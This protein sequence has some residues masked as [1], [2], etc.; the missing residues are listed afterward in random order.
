[1]RKR[2]EEILQLLIRSQKKI[3]IFSLKKRYQVTERTIRSDLAEINEF[4]RNLRISDIYFDSEGDLNTGPDFDSV[5]VEIELI[6]MN[7]YIYKMS[8]RERQVYITLLL[9]WDHKYLVMKDIA[10]KLYVSRLTVL[11]DFESIKEELENKEAEVLGDA[12]KG[13]CIRCSEE[14]R[15][16]LLVDLFRRLTLEV[17]NEGFFQRFVLEQLNI[18]YT[19]NEICSWAQ[20]YLS[21]NNLVFIAD[22]L[23]DTVLYLFVVF[24]LKSGNQ[25]T[26]LVKAVDFNENDDLIMYIGNKLGC[27]VSEE[28]RIGFRDYIR[29]YEISLYVKNLDEIEFY[30][31]IIHFLS[32]IDQELHLKLC[33]DNVLIDSLLLHIKNMR[34]WG[35]LEF[36]ISDL[37]EMVFDYQRVLTVVDKYLY[38][39]E[40]YLSY[41][42][43]DNMKKSI[44]IHICVAM[45]R[46]NKKSQKPSVV[47]VCPG[48]M[49]T[50][51]YLEAQIKNYF[52]FNI[53][54]L[55]PVSRISKQLEKIDDVDFIISTVQLHHLG[56][57]CLKVHAVLTMQ[58]MNL[59]QKTAFEYQNQQSAETRLK[60]N[61]RKIANKLQSLQQDKE[62][63]DRLYQKIETVILEYENEEKEVEKTAIGELLEEDSIIF[64]DTSQ[65]WEESIRK[66][67][68]ILIRKG[69][70][71]PK[72]VE[73]A[74]QN[75]RDYGDYIILGNG[76]AL[77]HAGK[78]YEVYKDGLSLLVSYPGIA[79]SSSEKK[80]NFLF[81][82]S[83]RGVKDY[84]ELFHEIVEI[85]QNESFRN[86]L[87]RMSGEELCQTLCFKES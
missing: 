71:G 84:I 64:D 22:A 14:K 44:M 52:D 31:I 55:F 65:D 48:S 45:I 81:C 47:I 76:V 34:D 43:N 8:P 11:N 29:N 51:R 3:S 36:E 39:L 63:P 40:K 4:L 38:V 27:P 58:D 86:S 54:G 35:D 24:N 15:K 18:Q 60:E 32:R 30:E 68:A 13:V 5:L 72:F 26:D 17:E 62:L 21:I 85:G 50:G 41:K 78:D 12:G 66:S 7:T 73:K 75:I 79:F 80:V 82:F 20:E 83:S 53:R 33:R 1:M 67:A 28:M 56:V 2:S 6:K 23:Y 59:I 74:I 57:K 16:E 19:F 49:A 77:A 70:I 10:D 69:C 37:N 42:I 46:N 61:E 87:L 25:K 9:L